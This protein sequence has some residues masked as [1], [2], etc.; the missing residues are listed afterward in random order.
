VVV[1]RHSR[2]VGGRK[3][4][5]GDIGTVNLELHLVRGGHETTGLGVTREEFD[6]VIEVEFLN[7]ALGGDRIL[8]LRDQEVLRLA[9]KDRAFIGI[10]IHVVR[11]TLPLVDRGTRTPRDSQFNIVILERDQRKRGLP[12]FAEKEAKRV[13]LFA[14]TTSVQT[15]RDGSRLISREKFRC[16]VRCEGRILFIDHLTTDQEFDLGNSGGPV[17]DRVRLCAVTL[18]RHEVDVV[19]EITFAFETNGRHTV[20]RHVTLDDLTFSR[21]REIRVTTVIRA[22][23]GHFGLANKM[24]ILGTHSHELSNSTRHFI[25]Y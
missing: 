4:E 7:L 12:V 2:E 11:V 1:G 18:D 13:E 9:G 5:V 3:F 14:S 19:E 24:R 15:T 16:D 6:R 25:L 10:Q 21:L 23:E 20:V 17:S 8:D 22:E